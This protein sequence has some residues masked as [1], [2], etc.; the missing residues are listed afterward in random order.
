NDAYLNGMG[1]SKRL[2]TNNVDATRICD[3]IPDPT[4]ATTDSEGLQ[5]IDRFAR[6]MRATKVPPR[7]TALANSPDGLAGASLFHNVGCDICHV[8]SITTAPAGTTVAAGAF[9][10]PPSLGNKLIH[11]YSD[12]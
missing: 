7:D 8:S 9:T 10:V 12:F 11:P 2:P 6:F 4:N 1:P 3:V 5:D